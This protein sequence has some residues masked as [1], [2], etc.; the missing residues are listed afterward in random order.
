MKHSFF[1]SIALS[2]WFYQLNIMICLGL[3]RSW[4]SSQIWVVPFCVVFTPVCFVFS[5]RWIAVSFSCSMDWPIGLDQRSVCAS[6][7]VGANHFFQVDLLSWRS[8]YHKHPGNEWR[9]C[10]QRQVFSPSFRLIAFADIIHHIWVFFSSLHIVC[11]IILQIDP[12][13]IACVG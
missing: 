9:C 4:S 13:H 1:F 2:F 3:C 10:L 8:C 12:S 7:L 6:K 11:L 5:R